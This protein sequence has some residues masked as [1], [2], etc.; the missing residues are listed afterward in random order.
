[1]NIY[2]KNHKIRVYTKDL[3]FLSNGSKAGSILTEYLTIE[4]NEND[5][6]FIQ[7]FQQEIWPYTV[8]HS[9]DQTV[10]T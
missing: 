7:K 10:P 3:Q 1:M 5:A 2:K 4:Y 6:I 9:Y 8:Y